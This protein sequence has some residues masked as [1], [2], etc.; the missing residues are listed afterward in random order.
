MAGDRLHAARGRR[1]AAHR[2]PSAA[3]R[4]RGGPDE[5]TPHRPGP[6]P[7]LSRPIAEQEIPMSFASLMVSVDLGDSARAASAS[8]APRRR[9]RRPPHRCR[10]RDARLRGG[11]HRS[12]PR[13]RLLPRLPPRRPSSTTCGPRTRPSTRRA[14]DGAASNGARTSTSRWSSWPARRPPPTWRSS[15]GRSRGLKARRRSGRRAVAARHPAAGG[16]AGNRPVRGAAVAVA[17]KSTREAHR[18]VRDALPFLARASHV[19]LL[20][21]PDGGGRR[22]RDIVGLLEA[23]DVP[24]MPSAGRPTAPP[25]PKPSSTPPARMPPT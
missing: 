19:S 8:P 11:A 5:K 15:A 1:H 23:H 4:L 12:D 24:S 6:N 3:L 16:S 7:D 18:A 21:V 20:T 22:T 17:W 10:S 13:G 14:P 25:P 9:V 2:D